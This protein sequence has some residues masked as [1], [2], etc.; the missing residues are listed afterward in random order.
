[1]IYQ[2]ETG[3]LPAQDHIG[4]TDSN[5]SEAGIGWHKSAPIHAK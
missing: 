1:M 2:A 4:K 5:K 3:K